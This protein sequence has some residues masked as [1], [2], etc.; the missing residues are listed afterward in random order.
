MLAQASFR[1]A[2]EAEQKSDYAGRG[3][4]SPCQVA[5]GSYFSKVNR[6]GVHCLLKGKWNRVS[7]TKH[8]SMERMTVCLWFQQLICLESLND[9]HLGCYN[10]IVGTV[11]DA[12][13]LVARTSDCG[14]GKVGH[15]V[16]FLSCAWMGG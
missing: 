5:V 4:F 7:Q 10:E 12:D 15:P 14:K 8:H 1:A 9:K 13:A 6:Y 2:R 3:T 16:N 11:C